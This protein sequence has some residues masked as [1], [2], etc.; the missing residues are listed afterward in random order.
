MIRRVSIVMVMTLAAGCIFKPGGEPDTDAAAIDAR[1]TDA[2]HDGMII[3]EDAAPVD[4]AVIDARPIDAR[5][6]D[7]TVDAP[8]D[9][10]ADAA[11][12]AATDAAIDAPPG[13]LVRHLT[14]DTAADFND[15]TPQLSEAYV[16]PA[17]RLAPRAYYY[18]G[19]CA[20]GSNIRLFTDA[21]TA[22]GSALPA[23]FT[24]AIVRF[25]NLDVV[26][27]GAPQAVGITDGTDWTYWLQGEVNLTA[28]NHNLTLRADD[29]GFLEMAPVG[30][31]TS[32][33]K[34]VGAST[35][36]GER[37][38]V[39]NA[40]TAGWYG[41]RYAVSQASGA[42]DLY[43][44]VD[45][46]FLSRFSTRCRADQ[47]QGLQQLVADEG[48]G[49]HV[50]G[51]TLD[52][53]AQVANRNW[54][55]GG[56]TDLGLLG[57]DT[58]SNRWSGQ[59][60]LGLAGTYTFRFDTDDGQR[61]WI[62]GV[63]VLNM[64]DGAPHNLTTAPLNLAAGYHDIVLETNEE[65]LGAKAILVVN[66]GP[67]LAG[68][69][70]PPARFRPAEARSER[71]EAV[72]H[73]VTVAIPG[74]DT[75]TV[76]IPAGAQVT[77]VDIGY[78][79][80]MANPASLSATLSHGATTTT[81]RNGGSAATFDRIN[82]TA[83]NG[84]DPNGNWTVTYIAGNGA[85][86]QALGAWLTVHYVE[87]QYKG[88]LAQTATMITSVRDLLAPTGGAGTVATI[89]PV[90]LTAQQAPGATILAYMRTCAASPCT[91]AWNGP[92]G[93]GAMP[94]VLPQ[95]YVQFILAISTDTDHDTW[96]DKFVLDYTLVG[97]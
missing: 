21:A 76:A 71:V 3:E 43:V 87:G 97:E 72:N 93:E 45:G 65:T 4:A 86:G 10:P 88:P 73:D 85:T 33:T 39:F 48:R 25:T 13:P 29:A 40:P 6:I 42:S 20:G 68:L 75:F 9:A 62:D 52:S 7:A 74:T 77:G 22:N 95:R 59:V 27:N 46:Q 91:G 34:V 38:V 78:Q 54:G 60:R 70:I 5:P 19:L 84:Q 2:R 63:R 81:L 30:V 24:P 26:D 49:V 17:G 36:D 94:S 41:I 50:V 96:L 12:D 32:F 11:T 15:G 53:S 56:P 64:F 69:V 61:V 37:T 58:W 90:H 66:S 16:D 80:N 18:G 79:L 55:F 83:F 44:K 47:L 35:A 89:G 57:N 31:T 28:G 23:Q 67:E 51:S 1:P 14:I 92:Y 82:T 8:T